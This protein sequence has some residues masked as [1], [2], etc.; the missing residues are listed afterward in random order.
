MPSDD[1][2]NPTE[3][4]AAA[5]RITAGCGLYVGGIVFFG[6]GIIPVFGGFFGADLDLSLAGGT[7]AVVS[8]V[9]VCLGA[10]LCLQDVSLS[11]R[12]AMTIRGLAKVILVVAVVLAATIEVPG[13]TI[14]A[15]VL[16]IM[17]WPIF[18]LIANYVRL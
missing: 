14:L 5:Q 16:T 6:C 12:R 1:A 17:F 3:S 11:I 4:D 15:L 13:L 10:V 9:P 8:L 7:L 18:L 2:K